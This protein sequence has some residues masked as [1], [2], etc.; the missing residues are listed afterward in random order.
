MMTNRSCYAVFENSEDDFHFETVVIPDLKEGEILIRNNYCTLCRSDLNTFIG[1]RK[2]KS[3]TILGHEVIGIIEGFGPIPP[4]A[5]LRGHEL[6]IGDRLTWAIYS[7]NPESYYSMKGIPQKGEDLLK[8]G[9]EQITK[10]N[11]L[12]GGLSEYTILRKNTPFVSIANEVPDPVAALLN[13]SIA[14]V[15]GAIRMAGD[16]KGKTVLVS[17]TGM[18]GI[19]A[20]AMA[21]KG[22]AELVIA[23]DSDLHRIEKARSFGADLA[24]QSD[25]YD[26]MRQS[27]IAINPEQTIRI[28]VVLEFSGVPEAME[29]TLRLL[30]IG[31]TAV[32]IGATY[33]QRDLNINAEYLIRNILTIKG[34]H[35]YNEQ[36]F[37]QG[38]NFIEQHHTSFNFESLVYNGFTLNK[39]N[40]AFKFAIEENPFR[41]GINLTSLHIL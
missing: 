14:T 12:H 3:P 31:G 30:D 38:V 35:N 8:Y 5:D 39:V 27:L 9:H 29:N 36:D 1:K 19:I 40:E 22:M 2:E 20:C 21:K 4:Q 26:V 41:V 33:P 34:L 37:V 11:N 28:D 18:L 32:W 13:C 7:S 23:A 17:G 16:L 10:E 6:K 15:A 24:I 25:K